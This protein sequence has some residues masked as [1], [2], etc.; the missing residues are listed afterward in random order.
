MP[1]MPSEGFRRHFCAGLKQ[2]LLREQVSDGGE[3]A[4]VFGQ[5]AVFF[6]GFKCCFVP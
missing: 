6:E 4:A 5:H 2:G 3:V 1:K